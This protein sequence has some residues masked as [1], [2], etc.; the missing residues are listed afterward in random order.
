MTPE[1]HFARLRDASN[2]AVSVPLPPPRGRR[3]FTVLLPVAIAAVL[4]IVFVAVVQGLRAP[5]P[6]RP[7]TPSPSPTVTSASQ[8]TSPPHQLFGGDCSNLFS[9]SELSA[10]FGN[11][12]RPLE[13]SW[14]Q[15]LPLNAAVAHNGGITCN[16]A[17]EEDGGTGLAVSVIPRSLAPETLETS[18]CDGATTNTCRFVVIDS[19]LILTGRFRTEA[20]TALTGIDAKL[21]AV[22]ELLHREAK[23]ITEFPAPWSPRPSD[24]TDLGDVTFAPDGHDVHNIDCSR[25]AAYAGLPPSTSEVYSTDYGLDVLGS[26][27]GAGICTGFATSPGSFVRGIQTLAGGGWLEAHIRNGGG[28]PVSLPGADSAYQF[29][30]HTAEGRT[31]ELF[32]FSH[33]NLLAVTSQA[34]TQNPDLAAIASRILAGLNGTSVPTSTPTS[35]VSTPPAGAPALP[36]LLLSSEG[37]GPIKIAQMMPADQKITYWLDNFCG[38]TGDGRKPGGWQNDYAR[39]LNGN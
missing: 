6:M 38:F 24:W 21:A 37:L 32:V 17:S 14:K 23:S 15:Y 10:A 39:N 9:S 31:V 5:H 22:T 36:D 3:V 28:E 11:S 12:V 18:D 13:L 19:G 8:W 35:P 26:D 20:T 25:I 16:W 34:G 4:V 33:E 29:A 7:A 27:H 1:E 2:W 30:Q